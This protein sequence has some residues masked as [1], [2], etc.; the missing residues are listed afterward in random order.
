MNINQIISFHLFAN[1][2]CIKL[3]CGDVLPSIIKGFFFGFAIGIIGC[4][5]GWNTKDGTE[6]V[7]RSANSAVVISIFAVFII[8]L[9]A[10][11]ITGILNIK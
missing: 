6:G 4:Y 5:K 9:I 3:S 1:Q 11:Q 10:A 2:V 8:D 7:G